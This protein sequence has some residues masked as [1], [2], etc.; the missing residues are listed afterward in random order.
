[1]NGSKLPSRFTSAPA[2]Y[3]VLVGVM[4]S[5]QV[6]L[7]W[8]H[9]RKRLAT[10][11]LFL[12]FSSQCLVWLLWGPT[13]LSVEMLFPAALFVVG[14]VFD[15]YGRFVNISDHKKYLLGLLLSG[16]ILPFIVWISIGFGMDGA[17][18]AVSIIGTML[19]VFIGYWL[20]NKMP[21]G[22]VHA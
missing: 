8:I 15:L 6:T 3:S 18:L 20:A 17:E 22:E 4:I 7:S 12:F 5:F 9:T 21:A 10:G 2:Y 16:F 1:M 13:K 14:I 19:S 11:I